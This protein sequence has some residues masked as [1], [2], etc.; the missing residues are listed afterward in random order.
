MWVIGGYDGISN[1]RDVLYAENGTTWHELKNTPWPERHASSVFNYQHSLW[2][3]AANRWNDL[4][5]LN[6]LVCPNVISPALITKVLAGNSAVFAANY[7]S[8]NA[9]YTWQVKN[10]SIWQ[11]AVSSNLLNGLNKD[12]LKLNF[13]SIANFGQEYRCIVESGAYKDKT[14]A[15]ALN[16]LFPKV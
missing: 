16:V 3:V 8:P 4:W 7:L 12:A 9:T 2:V 13:A 14:Y 10:N 5:R 1:R 15:S 11:N 6:N